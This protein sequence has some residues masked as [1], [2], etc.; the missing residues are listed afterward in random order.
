MVQL[1]PLFDDRHEHIDRDGHPDLR[2]DRV[3]RGAEKLLNPQVLLDPF[4]EQLDP[5][6]GAVQLGDGQRRELKVVGQKGEP[7][8][9]VRPRHPNAAQLVGI[10]VG[11]ARQGDRLVAAHAGGTVYPVGVHPVKAQVAFGADHEEGPRGVDPEQPAEIEVAPIQHV[12]RPGLG[13]HRIEQPHL[14]D[15]GRRDHH[16]RR[17]AAAQVQ[18]GVQLDGGLGPAELGPGE[19][20]QAQ[21]DGGGI[22]GVGGVVESGTEIVVQV[23]RPGDADQLVGQLLVD[24]PVPVLVGFGQGVAGD[25]TANAQMVQ[26]AA[27]RAQ[28]QFDVAQALPPG[29]LGEGQAEELIPAGER[30]DAV[31][32][33]IAG[34]ATGE[35]VVRDVVHQLG[36]Y[37]AA[38]VHGQRLRAG[39]VLPEM[40]TES[41]N[42]FWRKCPVSHSFIKC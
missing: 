9:G 35:Q 4:E 15:D 34:D 3:G 14:V 12:E 24:A 16:P 22:Q 1:Q 8:A 23:Q 40:L 25:V 30:A 2:L 42:R 31:V 11:L 36:E 18:Q 7:R 27:G 21:V 37:G 5:P 29:Q 6:A 41:S 10:G 26:L 39:N 19:Q 13:H 38:F 28:A 20:G 17:D 33:L 32:A